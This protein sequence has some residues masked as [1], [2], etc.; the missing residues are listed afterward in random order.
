MVKYHFELDGQVYTLESRTTLPL[1]YNVIRPDKTMV[2]VQDTVVYKV[3]N[4][5]S[6]LVGHV[7]SL[8]E[9]FL[10]EVY[11]EL[12]G[13]V[14][15]IVAPGIG[16]FKN[17]VLE[18]GNIRVLEFK[19]KGLL[20]DFY[21]YML[22]EISKRIIELCSE[23]SSEGIEL[24]LDLTHGINYMPTLTYRAVREIANILSWGREVTLKV[25][26]SEPYVQGVKDYNIHVVEDSKILP[27]AYT[28]A[29]DGPR[30]KPL[31]ILTTRR[32]GVEG[33]FREVGEIVG[34]VN[35]R[36]LNAFIG[37]VANGLPLTLYT[38]Y[39]DI[40]TL[41]EVIDETLS[42]YRRY[43]ILT[44][45]SDDNVVVEHKVA[46]REH[47][48]ILVGVWALA[49]ILEGY[50]S[51]KNIISLRDVKRVTK[52][53]LGRN[54][55]LRSMISR[56]IHELEGKI[57]SYKSAM[58]G[59]FDWSPL[60]TLFTHEYGKTVNELE[61]ECSLNELRRVRDK[62]RRNF[63]AHSGFEKCVTMVK[64]ENGKVYFKYREDTLDLI[65]D[66]ASRG[67]LKIP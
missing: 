21:S 20:Q 16:N 8:Y 32:G 37:S 54:E 46:F 58:G 28:K 56:D 34:K 1:I 3:L 24:H 38:L 44:P 27:V 23:H 4:D 50:I 62:F 40:K 14:D 48:N 45:I 36:E 30:I 10:D 61:R 67:L 51:R 49:S 25:Y 60:Y 63:L 26:N 18:N 42:L 11:P 5:Y 41:R 53:I 7:K 57:V 2:I 64:C 66:A 13:R 33:L 43:T 65:L 15:I 31:K 22:A 12:K 9:S 39:P 19:F 47:F 6:R 55:K 59:V 29:I 17:S 52:H 35:V